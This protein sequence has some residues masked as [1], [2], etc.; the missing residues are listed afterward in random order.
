MVRISK[1]IGSSRLAK[2]IKEQKVEEK[3]S[4]TSWSKKIEARIASSNRNDFE[5]FTDMIKKKH[6][7]KTVKRVV[8]TK[9]NKIKSVGNV[10]SS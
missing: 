2:F 5:R 7:N 6:F 9:L 1:G 8:K 10:T 3:W 4:N